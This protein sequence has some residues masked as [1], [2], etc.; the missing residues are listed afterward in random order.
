MKNYTVSPAASIPKN[1]DFSRNKTIA[2]YIKP[3][4]HAVLDKTY[5]SVLSLD[6]I[7][8]GYNVI[9]LN[10]VFAERNEQESV[11]K[12]FDETAKKFLS[13]NHTPLLNALIIAAPE[14]DSSMI[15]T[16]Y[17]KKT[18]LHG[19]TEQYGGWKVPTLS[20]ELKIFD[21]SSKEVFLETENKDT[22]RLYAPEGEKIPSQQE[23]P[24]IIVARQLTRAL[25]NIPVCAIEDTT[26]ARYHFPV[27]FYV[28]ESY[29]NRFPTQ[30]AERLQR[31]LLYA[32]DILRKQFDIELDLGGFNEWNARFPSSMDYVLEHLRQSTPSLA[33]AFL[34]GVTVDPQLTRTWQHRARLGVAFPFGIHAAITAQP[35]FPDATE[36]NSIEEALTLVH[37]IG[38]LLGAGH[39]GSQTSVMYPYSGSL[40]FLFDELNSQIIDTLKS[41]FF[42]LTEA[43]RLQKCVKLLVDSRS[44]HLKNSVNIIPQIARSLLHLVELKVHYAAISRDTTSFSSLLASEIADSSLRYAVTGYMEYKNEHLEQALQ[45]FSKAIEFAPDFAEA[46]GYLS[47]VL[48]KLNRSKD[49]EEHA[50]IARQFHVLWVGE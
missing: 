8:L 40:S 43:Q 30:W 6:L 33:R 28:D 20:C 13:T 50:N 9:D 32:S 5:A 35:S 44:S 45:Y 36:W 17:S 21:A 38:H 29:R 24:W 31:R 2:I 14:W 27:I 18:T 22:C 1:Y 37:E 4:D 7:S 39:S 23:H 15:V 47:T 26:A 48:I 46:H 10:L 3:F 49:A 41:Q 12:G 42:E 34:I 11:W 19:Y 25:K 16:E